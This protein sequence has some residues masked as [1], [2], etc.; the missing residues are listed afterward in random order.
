MKE[1]NNLRF[2][3]IDLN[4]LKSAPQ[5]RYVIRL[6]SILND[7]DAGSYLADLL[8]EEEKLHEYLVSSRW[9][10]G[11]VLYLLRHR[12][13]TIYCALK[14]IVKEMQAK[15][16]AAKSQRR[17]SNS[18]RLLWHT[19]L[20]NEDLTKR[21]SGLGDFV[22][23]AA[24]KGFKHVRDKLTAH[25]DDDAISAG[26]DKVLENNDLGVIL[27]RDS[28][29]RVRAIFVDDIISRSWQSQALNNGADN[30]Q[31]FREF[32]NS[33][34]QIRSATAEF[35]YLLIEA[36]SKEFSLGATDEEHES[37]RMELTSKGAPI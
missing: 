34:A 21:L 20:D 18:A 13:A 27:R 1:Q 28:P 24:D 6:L 10:D 17:N 15:V 14:D 32:V 12:N 16:E 36:Y 11:V 9:H 2:R 31:E 22:S 4:K 3:A 25:I 19:I 26:L 35:C 7:L 8:R 29:T 37:I 33:F 5:H 30:Q 23:T